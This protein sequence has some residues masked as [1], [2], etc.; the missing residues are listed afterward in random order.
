MALVTLLSFNDQRLYLSEQPEFQGV[1]LSLDVLER[2]GSVVSWSQL[3][4]VENL[5][6]S[7][8][9]DQ[10]LIDT[11]PQQKQ[12]KDKKA[13]M[14]ASISKVFENIKIEN[15]KKAIQREKQAEALAKA[16]LMIVEL[17]EKLNVMANASGSVD[18]A[19]LSQ[20]MEALAV[21]R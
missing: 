18:I 10:E 11:S 6:A 4:R 5:L 8:I 21:K 7:L 13:S 3:A 15:S 9:R 19:Q 1:P 14:M 2:I 12:L 16:T 20:K 17:T